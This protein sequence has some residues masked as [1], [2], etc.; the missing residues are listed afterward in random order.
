M[1]E[2]ATDWFH[3]NPQIQTL[4]LE[5]GAT[6]FVIDDVLRE[7]E[8][9]RD[10]AIAQREAFKPVDFNAY[11]GIYLLP[12]N[13][14]AHAFHAFFLQHMRPHFDARRVLEMQSRL[15]MVTRPPEQLRPFQWLCH[16][17]QVGVPTAYSIQASVLY[18]FEDEELGGTSFYAP[19][20]TRQE[21]SDL[22]HDASNLPATEFTRKRG[23][24]PSYMNGSNAYFTRIG[25]APARW[26]R[27]IFYDGNILHSGDIHDPRRLSSDPA[28]GRLT[29]NGFFTC[30]RH[31]T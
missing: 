15:A 31:T 4:R 6:C 9:L 30:R 14:L 13:A 8:R 7:P 18:L 21:I 17:D 2:D 3:P 28:N 1:T 20:R 5:H 12:P 16:S 24:P 29:F 22:Y 23:I 25:Q 27:M 19:S 11:P 10:W 26:N